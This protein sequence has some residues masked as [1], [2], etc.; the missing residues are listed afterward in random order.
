VR[1]NITEN[2]WPDGKHSNSTD[3]FSV[4]VRQSLLYWS[5]STFH[6]ATWPPVTYV[7]ASIGTHGE[8]GGR[9]GELGGAGSAGGAGGLGGFGGRLGRS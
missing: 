6:R 4:I 2:L 8:S 1:S 3:P 7:V 9:G 5:S